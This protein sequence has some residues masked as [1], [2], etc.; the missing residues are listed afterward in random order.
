MRSITLSINSSGYGNNSGAHLSATQALVN[1]CKSEV[2]CGMRSVFDT[3]ARISSISMICDY[4]FE[5]PE[6]SEVL[7]IIVWY[8]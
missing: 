3:E 6:V 2:R 5:L 8:R 4:V 1:A 7:G